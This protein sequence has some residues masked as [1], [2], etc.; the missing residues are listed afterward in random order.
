MARTPSSTITELESLLGFRGNVQVTSVNRALVQKWLT[1]NGVKAVVAK[2][3]PL[4]ALEDTYNDV[5][6]AMLDNYQALEGTEPSGVPSAMLSSH[7]EKTV[8]P[9]SDALEAMRVLIKSFA[10]PA[11]VTP[12]QGIS[13]EQ[14]KQA[15]KEE[16]KTQLAQ[17]I[18]ITI[19]NQ[20]SQAPAGLRHKD[21]QKVLKAITCGNVALIGAAG[22]GKTTLAEQVAEAL[23]VKFY[24]TGAIAS[25]YKLTGFTDA[26]G[27]TIRTAFREAYEH[28]GLF[29]FDEID[30]SL[31][32]A[33]LAFNAALAN[34]HAD[35][36]DG[37]VKR[38]KDFY[39]MAAANTFWTG[40]DRVYVGRNQ[41]D[42]ATLDRF[43][44]VDLPY[45]ENL[46]RTL[47]GND[48]WVNTVQEA[49]RKARELK[50]RHIV[51]PRASIMGA[52]L[53]AQGL[54]QRDVKAMALYKGLDQE[55]I[56]K[57]EA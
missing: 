7:E 1:A 23:G 19:N 40:A 20:T 36:P 41:L 35:F 9:N 10:Q 8:A 28:G 24:F 44:F 16:L 57:I 4:R 27:R 21:F 46:E 37:S 39:C 34:G 22:S 32:A 52:K 33:V 55:T 49:R 29:L 45:D 54:S 43:I 26:H 6:D 12:A 3:L 42:G 2:S 53:L 18:Q 14:L 15:V 56:K 25:E 50:I 47:A 31:P 51:S 13:T 38:H 30:G 11:P 5:S 48:D 17:P